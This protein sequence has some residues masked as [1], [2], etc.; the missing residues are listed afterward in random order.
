MKSLITFWGIIFALTC[1]GQLEIKDFP[2]GTWKTEGKEN[3]EHWD[4]LKNG[5]FA[6]FSYTMENGNIKVSE[7]LNLVKKGDTY[8]YSARVLNQNN[9]NAVDFKL[10]HSD[11]AFVFENSAH[12]FPKQ[13][14][15]YPIERD[16]FL[17]HVSDGKKKGFSYHII[18]QDIQGEIQDSTIQN[19]NYNAA[20]AKKTGADKYG[21]KSYIFV[22]LKSGTNKST[23]Q[24]L[25]QS[26]F[27]GHLDNINRLVDDKK[28]IVAGPFGTND[29][30]FRGLFILTNVESIEEAEEILQTDPA[31]KQ[32]FLSAELY[33]WYGSAALP[34]Y[35]EFSDQI[36]KIKP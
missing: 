15:Y 16:T 10:T 30:N 29:N 24:A 23:D 7:Y 31:I 35:L 17:V 21:M 32:N 28:L 19:P 36:W 18:K 8:V 22:I 9:G 25:M 6:G 20:L 27:R 12:S 1:F 5:S 26:C 34:E 14:L 13:I 4:K 3:Y 33:E 11:T 2:V